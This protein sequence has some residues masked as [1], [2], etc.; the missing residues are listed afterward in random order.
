MRFLLDENV[1]HGLYPFLSNLGY[2]V[3]FSPKTIKNGEV[4]KLSTMEN[5]ILITRDSDF[6]QYSKREN[7][8]IVLLRIHP[9]DLLQQ[10]RALSKFLSKNRKLENKTF[11]ISSDIDFE[12][13]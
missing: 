13:L 3:K 1:H 10:Q 12:L 7:S 4:F 5:R 11:R 8:G 6:V 9:K 2:D